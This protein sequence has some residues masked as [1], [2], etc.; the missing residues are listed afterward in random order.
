MTVALAVFKAGTLDPELTLVHA[1]TPQP[2]DWIR[3]SHMFWGLANQSH[4]IPQGADGF[5]DEL[6]I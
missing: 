4:S 3:G 1:E 2:H 5:K 6:K